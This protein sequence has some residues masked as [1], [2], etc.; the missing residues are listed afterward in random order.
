[1][2]DSSTSSVSIDSI[3]SL[4]GAT[5]S[6]R[7][8]GLASGIDVDS[9]VAKLMTAESQP[10]L[11]MQ[12]RLQQ[13][14]WQRDDYR[15]MN[16]LLSALQSTT[17]TMKLQGSYLA[18]TATSSNSSLV[19]ATAGVTAGNATYTLSNIKMAT[20]AYNNSSG[21]ITS[22]TDFDPS[23]SMWDLVSSGAFSN[24]LNW[25]VNEVNNETQTVSSDGTT[26][27]LKH[28]Y[29]NNNSS[30]TTGTITVNTSSGSPTSFQVVTDPD[31]FK[32][33][34]SSG[35]QVLLNRETGKLT[36]NQ[37]LTTGSTIMVPNYSYDMLDFSIATTATDG[38][39][40]N[41]KDFTFDPSASLN[42]MLTTIS[43][44]TVGV[45]AFYD[46]SN[47]MVSMTRTDTGN[48]NVSGK[49][50]RFTGD[51]LTKTLGMNE[52][53][54][55]DGT[56][57][58]YKVNG[59]PATSTSHS[60][61]FT[62]G[63]VTF[64]LQDN[65]LSTSD[66]ATIRVNTDSDTVYKSISDF[67]DKYNDTIKQIND[68]LSETRNRDYAPLTDAQK[69][70]MSDSDITAWTTKAQSGM[71]SNDSILS[72]ALSQM[73]TDL[74]SSVSGTSNSNMNQLAEIGITTSNDYLD[75]GK[76][77]ISDPDKLKQAIS[78]NPQAVMEMFTNTGTDSNSQGIMQRL[79]TT[80]KNT[81]AKIED[82]AGNTNM[83]S[84]QYS[85]GDSI[86][87]MND[88]IDAFKLRLQSIQ[89]RYYNQF[90]AMEAAINQANSQASYLSQFT[91]S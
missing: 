17:Q 57:A 44:S 68:K 64:T 67:V 21:A 63:G 15:S 19:T 46:A 70:S 25:N 2:A 39:T 42:S 66:S 24:G 91:S 14:E 6:N 11:Q 45:T 81:M 38:T 60:N 79:N 53:N 82:K 33:D 59:L 80:L 28:A 4:I 8:S 32:T 55:Q 56:D 83:T 48:L 62:L 61:T 31:E 52:A 58:S 29:I 86:D 12:Q 23:K 50:I 20:S 75:H 36:F 69:S 89:T 16:T 88:R 27:S 43:Q 54:E 90:D 1:M 7:V 13:T 41:K 10:L 49:E 87:D 5:T 65:P 74:Y 37:T 72:S 34:G 73:R 30:L 77:I 3:N 47:K 35:A 51:L 40:E 22:K 18:K 84:S 78:E 9:I 76:L 71:L 85:M 26:F